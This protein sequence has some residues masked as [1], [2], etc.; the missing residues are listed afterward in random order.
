MTK[1]DKAKV[2]EAIKLLMD[3]GGDFH[4]AIALLGGLVG[5]TY[6]AYDEINNCKKTISLSDLR[7]QY[8][9]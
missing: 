2:T 9:T 5:I 1:A 7:K 8:E 6:P 3:D 4:K